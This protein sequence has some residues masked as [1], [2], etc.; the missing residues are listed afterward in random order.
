MTQS[1]TL[2]S[3]RPI[4][5]ASTLRLT[6]GICRCS[7]KLWAWLTI[8]VLFVMSP[9]PAFDT[10]YAATE[11]GPW[12]ADIPNHRPVQPGEHPRLL[13]RQTDLPDLRARAAT[14]EGQAILK[15][16]RVQLNGGD[17][18]SLPREL[19]TT[20]RPDRDG[21]GP[22]AGRPDG[23]VLTFS[24][25]AGYG[26]L[27]QMTG[28]RHYADL[29][30]QAMEKMLEGHRGR[31]LRYSFRQPY[32]ALRSGPVLG[33]VALGYDLCYDGW[34]P[35]FREKIAREI[36]QYNEGRHMSL[37]ELVR[38]SRHE[39][40]SNHWGMQVGGGAMAILAIM[41]DPGVDM[42]V[43]N[44]LFRVS[45][46]AM[47]RN[48]TEGFGEGGYFAEG[49]GCGTM[50]SHIIYLSALQAWKVAAGRDFITP[51]PYAR[52]T[53]LRW[54]HLTVPQD[55]N[56]GNLRRGF[57][58]RGGYPQNIWN[59]AGGVSGAGYFAIGYA[60]VTPEERAGIWWWYNHYVRD[61]DQANGTPFDTL[62]PYPHHSILAFVNTPFDLEPVNPAQVMPRQVR[63]QRHQFYGFRNRWQDRND[64][65]ITQLVVQSPYRFR[66]G[67]DRHMVIQ[68]A[69]Q[70]QQWGSIP[71][72]ARH[73]EPAADGSTIIG[74]EDHW[75]AIDFSG[76]S[77]AEAMLV[78]TGQNAPADHRLT[79]GG[80]TFAFKF[81][82]T[83][84]AAG[85]GGRSGGV[86]AQ[87]RVEGNS[88]VVGEQVV[89]MVDG[90][91]QLSRWAGP[92]QGPKTA[93]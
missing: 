37:A 91:L 17:G 22:L 46:R 18:R 88:I 77:G 3:N 33:W 67:P 89:T 9:Y 71:A 21:S 84:G 45:E 62:G 19:G 29:G 28:D 2:A 53:A 44:P 60:S 35:A 27:Y 48:V 79:V 30:R 54:F 61:W 42:N 86:P 59:R 68:H 49:D 7:I 65:V 12:P 58:E 32:G 47:I 64:I 11:S 39:P 50:A 6:S 63:D 34:E 85:G 81:I 4:N 23:E 26:F 52:W 10:A 78:M 25:P 41:N 69:G 14:P 43:I 5:P 13:F 73:W 20:R 83:S 90:K 38:G 72:N 56:M 87:P 80:Q 66:H 8:G 51:R 70:R 92:W 76:A 40:R 24:H 55:D 15:R 93:R 82:G 75:V 57:V 36:A 31:D 74:R 1:Q 16:L